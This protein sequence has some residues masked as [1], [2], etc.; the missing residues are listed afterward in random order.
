MPPA[1]NETLPALS[2]FGKLGATA[3]FLPIPAGN[4]TV[5]LTR[6]VGDAVEYVSPPPVGQGLKA[7]R[8]ERD[9]LAGPAVYTLKAATADLAAAV[10][11]S[12]WRNAVAGDFPDRTALNRKSAGARRLA[13]FAR[14]LL[15]FTAALHRARWRLG[16]VEPDN[17]YLIE[18][19]TTD[20]F[21]PDLGFAWVG[22]VSLAKPNWLRAEAQDRTLWEEERTTR[23]YAAPI[24]YQK[25]LPSVAWDD[26]VQRDLRLVARVLR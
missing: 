25:Y 21:L 8:W 11:L 18:R 6:A 17:L 5:K 4:L 1:A 9:P 14:A 23:Q 2:A 7:L 13:E 15:T 12:R 3:A 10:P 26:V 22:T 19:E 20:V 24:H 16:L